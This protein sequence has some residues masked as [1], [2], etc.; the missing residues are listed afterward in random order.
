MLKSSA[1]L[2]KEIYT[3]QCSQFLIQRNST[4]VFSLDV[5]L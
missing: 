3:N 1:I 5:K 2:K 4:T